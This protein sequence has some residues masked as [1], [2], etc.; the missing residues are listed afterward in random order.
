MTSAKIPLLQ[1]VM[2][3]LMTV[4]WLVLISRHYVAL[5]YNGYYGNMLRFVPNP[6]FLIN[7]REYV[8]PKHEI[9]KPQRVQTTVTSLLINQVIQAHL[10]GP[11]SNHALIL[12]LFMTYFKNCL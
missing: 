5:A 3:A 6:K 10:N 7:S 1:A 2:T 12:K 11:Q 8:S 4:K 9:D